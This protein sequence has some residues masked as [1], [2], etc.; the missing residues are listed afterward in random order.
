MKYKIGDRVRI[1]PERTKS[2]NP[3]GDMDKYLGKVVTISGIKTTIITGG[4]Y[5]IEE[6]NG[7]WPWY[8]NSIAGLASEVPFDFKAWEDKNVCMH[9]K[10]E[11]ENIDFCKEMDKAGLKW[12]GGE[13]YLKSDRFKYYREN[14]VYYF[15]EGFFGDV[16]SAKYR[17]SQILEWSDYRSTEPP[18]EEQEEEMETKIDDKPLGYQEAMRIYERMCSYNKDKCR[19]CPI[20][21][22]NNAL[23]KLCPEF[24]TEDPDKAE[25]ILKQWAAE[26]PAKTNR[27]KFVEVFGN[28]EIFDTDCGH[29]CGT[30]P[31]R[32]CNWWKQE[33][34]EPEERCK[35]CC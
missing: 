23:S 6:D 19:S 28:I 31:C 27:D 32:T 17:G 9:C 22:E 24:I 20:S 34:V 8:E 11:E 10:T 21:E 12:I 16:E 7:H 33:Y 26:H 18:K 30:V 14:T 15:N 29:S 13:P 5:I 25:P 1:V 3:D 4:Y 35:E 2:M